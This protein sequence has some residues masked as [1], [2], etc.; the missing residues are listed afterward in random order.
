MRKETELKELIYKRKSTRAYTKT[1]VDSETLSKIKEYIESIEPLFPEIKTRLEIVS[2]DRVRSMFKWLPEY[3]VAAFSEEVEGYLENVGFILGK[4]DLYLH[5]LGLGSCWIGM[6]RMGEGC[7]DRDDGQRFVILL[8][9]GYPES[10]GPYRELSDFNRKAL[11]EISDTTDERLEPA[12]LS[13]SSINSQPWYFAHG[14]DGAVH[15][16]RTAD[17]FLRAK[18]IARFNSIDVGIAIAHLA[19]SYPD[20]FI[21]RKLDTPPEIKGKV[22]VGTVYI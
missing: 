4:L 19:V 21:Y 5:S 16:Y 17:N 2:R 7:A 20:S 10:G 15:V 11:S 14:E 8:F 1:P 9:F 13:P 3:A 6:G 22:Y 18:V 12:R